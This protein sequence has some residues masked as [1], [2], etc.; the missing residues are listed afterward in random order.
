[1]YKEIE[2][3]ENV[4]R[5]HIKIIEIIAYEVTGKKKNEDGI[6]KNIEIGHP[7]FCQDIEDELVFANNNPGKRTEKFT[8]EVLK[9]TAIRYLDDPENVKQFVR[10]EMVNA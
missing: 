7:Y 4:A 9:S 8:V 10:K 1:M 6:E 5:G 2:Q 3:D